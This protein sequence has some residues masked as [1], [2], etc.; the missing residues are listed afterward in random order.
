MSAFAAAIETL[1]ADP[2]MGE[3]AVYTAPPATGIPVRIIVTRHD[4]VADF[5]GMQSHVRAPSW[6]VRVKQSE[7]PV[8]PRVRVDLLTISVGTFTIN[9]VIED[10][11]RRTWNCDLGG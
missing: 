7:V 5:P 1:H 8:R 2:N 6:E 9:D 11:V 4:P 3:D 10:E